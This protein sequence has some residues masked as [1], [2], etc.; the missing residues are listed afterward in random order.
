MTILTI[1]E[2]LERWMVEVPVG[3]GAYRRVPLMEYADRHAAE[4]VTRALAEL[5]A[6]VE[7]MLLLRANTLLTTR[8]REL[9]Y[10]DDVLRLIDE[11]MP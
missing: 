6:K 1:R 11:A 3:D 5:R 2:Q 8:G 9:V 4:A 10:H 7:V